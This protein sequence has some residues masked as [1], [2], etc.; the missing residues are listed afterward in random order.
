VLAAQDAEQAHACGPFSRA[1]AS[2]PVG[3]GAAELSWLKQA[4][5]TSLTFFSG[6]LRTGFP[7]AA[8]IAFITAGDTT[9]M[10]GSPMSPQKS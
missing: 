1:A 3:D 9:A 4:P 5:N 7:V 8:W 6:R 2:S 10:V